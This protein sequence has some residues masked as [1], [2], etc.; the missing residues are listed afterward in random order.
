MTTITIELPDAIAQE[1]GRAGLLNPQAL[2]VLLL[3]ALKR[4][5]AAQDL[6]SLTA[7]MA[8]SGIEPMSIEDVDAEVKAA[9]A[10]VRQRARG[11]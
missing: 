11:H 6:L 10:E 5:G 2:N 9:R 1:A 8:D 4:K 7:P 3:D